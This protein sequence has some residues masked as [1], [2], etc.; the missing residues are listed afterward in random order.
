MEALLETAL[1]P[2]QPAVYGPPP[3]PPRPPQ[4]PATAGMDVPD[5]DAAGGDYAPPGATLPQL[6]PPGMVPTYDECHDDPSDVR[7]DPEY[8]V[9]DECDGSVDDCGYSSTYIEGGIVRGGFG[10]YFWVPTFTGAHGGHGG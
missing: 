6:A 8:Y 9:D 3:P 7:C 10:H 1:A 4:N 2:A 5:L